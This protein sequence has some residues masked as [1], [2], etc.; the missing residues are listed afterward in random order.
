MTRVLWIAL[1]L[2]CCGLVAGC[3]TSKGSASTGGAAVGESGGGAAASGDDGAYLASVE[4]KVAARMEPV[5]ECFNKTQAREK[6]L[7]GKVNFEWTIRSDG[8]VDVVE[9]KSSTMNNGMVEECIKRVIT[10]WTFPTPPRDNFVVSHSFV[11][12]E[13]SK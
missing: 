4:E 7:A 6:T 2:G 8:K 9:V 10:D 13:K 11:F 12:A 5:Q 1:L 3:A